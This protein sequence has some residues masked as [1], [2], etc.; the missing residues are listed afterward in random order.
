MAHHQA[1][2]IIFPK[3]HNPMKAIVGTALRIIAILWLV[4]GAAGI[5]LAFLEAGSGSFFRGLASTLLGLGLFRLGTW[6][7]NKHSRT[8]ND[9]PA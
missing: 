4:N 8:S 3:H 6:L 5:I 7:K 2:S 1:I 9:Q